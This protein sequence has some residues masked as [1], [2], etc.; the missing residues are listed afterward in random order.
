MPPQIPQD[1]V[2]STWADDRLFAQLLEHRFPARWVQDLHWDSAAIAG[3][4]P[5]AGALDLFGYDPRAGRILFN[6]AIAAGL[7]RTPHGW[8]ALHKTEEH[9]RAAR[10]LNDLAK[11]DR[12]FLADMRDHRARKGLF[13]PDGRA[14]PVFQYNRQPGALGAVLWPLSAYYHEIGSATYFGAPETDDLPFDAKDDMLFWR[15]A[16]TGHDVGGQRAI[17]LLKDHAAGRISMQDCAERLRTVP[18]FK[19][20]DMY[21]KSPGFDLAFV[22]NPA[23]PSVSQFGYPV[24]P[25]T[26]RRD[27]LRSR[28]QLAIG[29]NDHASNL[30]WLLHSKSLVFLQALDWQLGYTAVLQAW[31]HYVPVDADLSDLSDKL[32]W[33]RAH[34]DRCKTIIAQAN[35]IAERLA[36]KSLERRVRCAVLNRYRQVVQPNR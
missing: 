23:N 3:T 35:A 8:S 20:L 7:Y 21:A 11:L 15:G 17:R 31:E 6:D 32:E 10:L 16:P 1:Q 4:L 22:E 29:G 2:K 12:P 5:V 36:S 9:A 25:A 26:A 13:L 30:P 34:P 19:L 14:V 28:Y 33:A 18:R 27:M 24:S